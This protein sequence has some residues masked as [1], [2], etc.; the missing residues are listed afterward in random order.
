MPITWAPRALAICTA[1]CPTPPAAAWISTRWPA[2]IRAFST[3][4]CHAVS[5]TSGSAAAWTWS[6]EAGLGANQAA[7]AATY[8]AWAPWPNGYESMP[9]TSSPGENRATPMPTSST[10]PDRSQPRTNGGSPMNPPVA[11]C[12]QSV[13]L[14]LA[15]S[16]RMRTSLVR[17]VGRGRSTTARTSGSPRVCCCTARMEA[18]LVMA[19]G[20]Q[21]PGPAARLVP[22]VTRHA[23]AVQHRGGSRCRSTSRSA[24]SAMIAVMYV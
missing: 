8:S 18:S 7:G 11:R 21:N 4:A 16:T 6:S 12:F 5:E 23:G 10:T 15:A 2:W 24:P 3:S 9:N 20:W 19:P 1:T 22:P 14:T 13:G 17:G